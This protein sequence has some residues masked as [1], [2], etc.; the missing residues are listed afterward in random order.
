MWG[1]GYTPDAKRP[2]LV[3]SCDKIRIAI[4]VLS[5]PI[6]STHQTRKSAAMSSIKVIEFKAYPNQAAI[7]QINVNL[8][9]CRHVWNE[10]LAISLEQRYR[11]H[12]SQHGYPVPFGLM[13]KPRILKRG[14]KTVVKY[15]GRGIIRQTPKGEPCAPRCPVRT[16]RSQMTERM[17]LYPKTLDKVP[18]CGKSDSYWADYLVIRDKEWVPHPAFQDKRI[19]TR[20]LIGMCRLVFSEAWK[21]YTN[22]NRPNSKKPK[23]KGIRDMPRTLVNMQNNVRVERL[24]NGNGYV[25]FP[26]GLKMRVKGL[27]D[28]LTTEHSTV[29]IVVRPSGYYVQFCVPSD[30]EELKPNNL[31]VGIDP[32]VRSVASLAIA[33]ED[34]IREEG[35]KYQPNQHLATLQK[36][37]KRLQRKLDRQKQGGSEWQKTKTLIAKSNEKISRSRN[38]FNHKLST[39]I[40]RK[41]GAIAFEDIKI[42]DMVRTAKPRKDPDRPGHYLPNG[43]TAKARQ[44]RNLLNVAIGDFKEKTKT[45]AQAAGRKFVAVPA[46]YTSQTCGAC[47]AIAAESVKGLRFACIVCGHK[48]DVD[49]NAAKN[50]LF[51]SGLL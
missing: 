17:N 24:N 31:K 48:D 7:E 1:E 3:E 32:G 13:F 51:K 18:T 46:P 21:A 41:Y 8:E 45:K 43:A 27:F 4:A 50:I 40:V 22:K 34:G 30:S 2:Q 23:F 42:P 39:K 15:T 19:C 25:I 9:A 37:L 38:A 47:G 11:Y 20:F 12:R 44:S 16:A 49:I 26:K 14:K 28:R 36:R 6:A 35:K 29:K 5:I 10:C 33:D